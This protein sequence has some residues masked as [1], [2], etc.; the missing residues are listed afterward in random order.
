MNV[1][2]PRSHFSVAFLSPLH[3]VNGENSPKLTVAEIIRF[4]MSEEKGMNFA[5]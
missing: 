5:I 3:S 4:H 2:A 1:F